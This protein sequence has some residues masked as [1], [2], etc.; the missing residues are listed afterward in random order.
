[1]ELNREETIKLFSDKLR[2]QEPFC[3]DKF[4]D[5]CVFCMQGF[6]GTN[7]EGHK[8]S[9]KLGAHLKRAYV[10][11]GHQSDVY[12]GEWQKKNSE[13]VICS[14]LRDATNI[15]PNFAFF[16]A[17]LMHE[18]QYLTEDL[19]EFY[20]LLKADK[21]PKHYFARE[22]MR[23]A[24]KMFNLEFHPVDYPNSYEHISEVL[25]FVKENILGGSIVLF[26][27]GML[28]KVMVYE[29]HRLSRA[30]TAIDLGS[31]LDP[32]FVGN[33]RSEQE[34]QY[35]KVQEFMKEFYNY[36]PMFELLI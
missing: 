10:Y 29:C 30:L 32:M 4:G 1:M 28:S 17:L 2:N 27:T 21:R 8:Y 19:R 24:A 20:R 34:G 5:D 36:D 22:R 23:E 12:I 33:T 3:F 15:N 31:A 9:Q 11:L 16:D 35:K 6:G 26:S 14:E 13:W 25:D 18:D 7:A